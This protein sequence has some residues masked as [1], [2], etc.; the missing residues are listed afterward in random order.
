M[1]ILLINHYAGSPEMGMEF[2][3]YYLAKHWVEMGHHIT[4]VGA[5]FSHLRNRQPDL[6]EK[7]IKEEWMD[8]IRYLWIQTNTYK[9]NGVG[10]IINILTFIRKLK[11]YRELFA[12]VIEPD[13]V[14]ASSTYPLDIYP[15]KT[16]AELSHAKLI[17][18]VHDLWP[19]SPMEI[20]GYP[21]SHPFIKVIQKGE[22]AA[23]KY[24]DAIV[25][26][27]PRADLHLVERGMDISKYHWIPNG[28]VAEDW[29]TGEVISEKNQQIINELRREGRF[30]IGYAGGHSDSNGL[31]FII[32][33]LAPLN[34][35]KVTAVLVGDGTRKKA[36]MERVEGAGI[37]NVVFLDKIP[38]TQIP[39]F[40]SRMDCLMN[41][42]KRTE[43]L[44]YGNSYNKLFD[45]M[46]AAKPI[47]NAA[48]SPNNPVSDSDCGFSIPAEDAELLRETILKVVE[49]SQEERIAMGQKGR[50]YVLEKYEYDYLSR[51][52]MNILEE[53]VR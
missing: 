6:Q 39:D 15:A 31:D 40:L 2:R 10:R 12:G 38:K 35:Q 21:A 4:I 36:M 52:F 44:K 42:V 17:F 34:E 53:L 16:I 18:E 5:S 45:Y 50:A 19:F 41:V 1:N 48:L 11:K 51:K 22:D 29:E 9:G 23:C 24:S 28:I 37:S 46:M 33:A 30:L 25:S 7:D 47:I 8:G 26:L 49:M 32:D 43:L 3:P 14:I 13:V 20:K 27:L